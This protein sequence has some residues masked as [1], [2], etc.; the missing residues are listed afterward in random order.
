MDLAPPTSGR[1]HVSS[2]LSLA[3]GVGRESAPLR[4]ARMSQAVLL[5]LLVL[6]LLLG[7]PGCAHSSLRPSEVASQARVRS[8]LDAYARHDYSVAELEFR[9]ALKL[10][11]RTLEALIGLG[12]TLSMLDKDE[13]SERSF[14]AALAIAPSNG[15][16]WRG[17]GVARFGLENR[18]GAIEAFEKAVS[19]EPQ[20]AEARFGLGMAYVQQGERAKALDQARAIE[21]LD[22]ELARQLKMI[23]SPF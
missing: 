9:E 1:M 4:T 3:P 15:R 8:G 17:L 23:L 19:L 20:N 22:P 12:A 6:G 7:G 18:A 10:E 14:L 21:P 5:A 2:G 13:E 11:P 16:A